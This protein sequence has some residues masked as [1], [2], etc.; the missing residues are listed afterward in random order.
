MLAIAA[1]GAS[2]I[3]R[4]EARTGNEL[5]GE[6]W[7]EGNEGRIRFVRA[8]D[9]TFRGITTC[10]RPKQPSDHNP[11]QDI[12]NPDPKLRARSTIGI[13]IIWALAYEDVAYSGGYVYNPR[14]GKTYRMKARLIERD[15]LRIRGYLAIPLLGQSQ[16]WKRMRAQPQR[17]NAEA[18]NSGRA[19]AAERARQHVAAPG[20]A[21]RGSRRV[22]RS[23][24]RP[25]AR[26]A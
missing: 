25:P 16:V 1:L 12:H 7:T 9:G 23:P 2:N 5:L 4:A 14:D 3:A 6:W 26:S 22:G 11:V 21:C 10:C 15:T 24:V 20:V 13:A 8:P 17:A 18:R 19:T